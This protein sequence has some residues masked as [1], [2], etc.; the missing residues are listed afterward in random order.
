MYNQGRQDKIGNLVQNEIKQRERL[1]TNE[2]QLF[3]DGNRSPES[4][5][6][7][8]FRPRIDNF[9][10]EESKRNSNQRFSGGYTSV[11]S[12]AFKSHDTLKNQST[13]NTF[14]GNAI[15]QTF[16]ASGNNESLS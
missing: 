1:D 2:D 9:V 8:D 11:A 16:I 10:V 12:G 3:S 5:E 7:E 14:Q 15:P 6:D 13:G 4:S